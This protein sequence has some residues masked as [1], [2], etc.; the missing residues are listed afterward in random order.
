MNRI[1][2]GLR[3][4]RFKA[5]A[6]SE[7]KL[8]IETQIGNK[9]TFRI[10]NA[11]LT[12]LG[13]W[14]V[15]G[16]ISENEIAMGDIVP[17]SKLMWSDNEVSLGRLVVRNVKFDQDGTFIG[18]SCIDTKV[19]LLG[20]LSK[21]FEK[22]GSD[23]SPLDFELSSKKYTIATFLEEDHSHDDLFEKCRQFHLLWS[24]C[25]KNPMYQYYS[26]RNEAHGSRVNFK[27]SRT[28]K[29][30]QYINFASF[31]YLGLSVDPEVKEASKSAIDKYGLSPGGSLALSGKT[32]LHEELEATI[33]KLLGKEDALLFNAGYA[34]NVGGISAILGLN[35]VVFADIFSHASIH[36]GIALAKGKSRY[37]KHNSM[38]HLENLLKEHRPNYAGALLVTEGLFSMEGDAPNLKELVRLAKQHNARTFLDECHSFGILG[39]NGMGAAER[40]GVLD[41]IDLFM[42]TL[43]KAFGAGGGFVCGSK[44]VIGWM[45]SFARAGLFSVGLTPSSVA[46]SLKSLEVHQNQPELRARLK[47]NIAQ[48][49]E[50][51]AK[52]GYQAPSDPESP[53]IP[54]IVGDDQ[55]IGAMNQVL[56]DKGVFVNPVIFPAVPVN[57]AR[58]RFSLSALHT[59][60]D[61]EIALTAFE[62]AM[63]ETRFTFSGTHH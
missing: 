59:Q 57:S 41:E 27:L 22:T 54:V 6:G 46:A 39:P 2:K 35:D 5:R 11:A 52:L 7:I 42:G 62:N 21:M 18:V 29:S 49:R 60:S 32:K 23:E 17:E 30:A 19:P 48:L 45:R 16:Q 24:D 25:M 13:G 43:S 50:G 3:A 58:F 53:V 40:D 44:K 1:A 56:L 38:K 28:K 15:E 8:T 26:V 14:H 31:D 12:G 61:I 10:E 51:L 20:S 47:A 34:A 37:F 33:S 36:D 9:L 55:K 63:Q 4:K